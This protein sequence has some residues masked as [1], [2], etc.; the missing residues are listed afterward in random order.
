MNAAALAAELGDVLPAH[1]AR[2]RWFGA[3]HRGVF[4]GRL[5]FVCPL[6]NGIFPVSHLFNFNVVDA[7]LYLTHVTRR[8]TEWTFLRIIIVDRDLSLQNDFCTGRNH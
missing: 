6:K 3:K 2:Q 7:A 1:M 4:I 5:A 8:F